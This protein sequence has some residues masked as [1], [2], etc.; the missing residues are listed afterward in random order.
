[1]WGKRER[2]GINNLWDWKAF[3]LTLTLHPDTTTWAMW[4]FLLLSN[5][6]LWER[7][8]DEFNAEFCS[9]ANSSR[10][11][12]PGGA[13]YLCKFETP[14]LTGNLSAAFCSPCSFSETLS[15]FI[16][17]Q[18]DDD[19]LQDDFLPFLTQDYVLL[20]QEQMA[21]MGGLLQ[22]VLLSFIPPSYGRA[23][24]KPAQ[25]HRPSGIIYSASFF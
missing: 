8:E 15:S 12:S 18:Q 4:I 24:N 25:T 19:R 13:Y 17:R 20:K 9:G 21:G 1:M 16:S 22:N 23:T 7:V 14:P 10:E 5:S 2:T 11:V 6:F 3:T